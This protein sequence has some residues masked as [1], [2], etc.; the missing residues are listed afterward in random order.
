MKAQ[1]V[2]FRLAETIS[3]GEKREQTLFKAPPPSKKRKKKMVVFNIG[4]QLRGPKK[5]PLS[6]ASITSTLKLGEKG[7]IEKLIKLYVARNSLSLVQ[8]SELTA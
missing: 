7:S 5:Q 1:Y 2:A 3:Q 4:L 8:R 6:H